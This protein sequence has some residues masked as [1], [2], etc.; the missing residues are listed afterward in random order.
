MQCN[1]Y[2]ELL[3]SSVAVQFRHFRPFL[4]THGGGSLKVKPLIVTQVDAGS[5]PVRRPNY[6]L[7]LDMILM[8]SSK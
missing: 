4:T 5:V 7:C 8:I 1:G 6:L 2:T 3:G